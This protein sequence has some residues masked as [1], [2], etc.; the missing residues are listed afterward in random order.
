MKIINRKTLFRGALA[1]ASAACLM[2]GVS[3]AT[4]G[5][6]VPGDVQWNVVGSFTDGSTLTGNFYI[7]ADG[8]F[9]YNAPWSLTTSADP[10]LGFAGFTY[11]T[12]NSFISSGPNQNSNLIYIDLEPGYQQDLHLQFQ[13][14]LTVPQNHNSIITNAS[15]ECV[16]SYSCYIPDISNGGAVRYLGNL[17]PDVPVRDFGGGSVPEP[18][19]WALMLLGFGGIGATMRMA[20]RQAGGAFTTV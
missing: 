13:A 3:A 18:S 15:Y 17:N 2:A 7:N 5:N 12:S 20:R 14:P 4:A 9:D 8:F 16:L 1:V 6:S 11:N 10:T 19:T